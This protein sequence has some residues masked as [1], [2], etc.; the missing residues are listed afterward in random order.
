[1]YLQCY[2]CRRQVQP[3]ILVYARKLKMGLNSQ[4][5]YSNHLKHFLCSDLP[6]MSKLWLVQEMGNGFQ[7]CTF[8]WVCNVKTFEKY[9]NFNCKACDTVYMKL[10]FFEKDQFVFAHFCKH[11]TEV[12]N[13]ICIRQKI[14][15]RTMYQIHM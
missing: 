3:K 12:F 6:Q 4:I 2:C 9:W 8:K 10:I 7:C 13:I 14:F 1:M 11:E 5:P 15:E